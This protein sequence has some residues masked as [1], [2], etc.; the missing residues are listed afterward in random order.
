ME[1]SLSCHGTCSDACPS[2]T[3][4]CDDNLSASFGVQH[5]N[6]ADAREKYMYNK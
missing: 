1:P 3:A 4:C 2:L 6:Q 5:R